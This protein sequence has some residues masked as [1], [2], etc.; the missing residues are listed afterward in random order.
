M[1]LVASLPKS[2]SFKMA[3]IELRV[4]RDCTGRELEREGTAVTLLPT[5][6]L[7]LG[8]LMPGCHTRRLQLHIG[9]WGKA[10]L[11]FASEQQR[12]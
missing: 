12:R 3:L 10:C 1:S 4:G 7:F 8:F 11:C 5:R 2:L 6:S 9:A